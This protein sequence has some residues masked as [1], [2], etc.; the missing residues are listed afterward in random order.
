MTVD[1][2]T[3]LVA[4][5]TLVDELYQR[6]VGPKRPVRRGHRPELSDSEV[7]TL[8]VCAQW[9]G[10]SE[11][12]FLRFVDRYWR[13]YFPRLLGQSAFNRRARDLT[14]AMTALVPLVAGDL[15]AALAPYQVIDGVAMP[16]ARRA[17]GI[18]HRLFADE[19]GIGRGGADK[20]W[21]FGCKVLLSCAPSGAITGFVVGLADTEERWLAEAW[22]CWRDEPTAS[23]WDGDHH[24]L[25]PSH[26]RGGRHRGPT[27]PI[28]PRDGAGA[29]ACGPT[30]ADKGFRGAHWAAHWW[31]DYGLLIRTDDAYDG[32]DAPAAR[33]H[34]HSRRQIIETVNGHLE[35]VFH[36]HF[37]NARSFRGLRARLAAKLLAFNLGLRLNTLL[38]R[39]PLALPTLWVA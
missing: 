27:G 37:P 20:D 8:M 28:W 4:L 25:P 33:R 26:K 11:R 38:G 29:P 16:L 13:G 23:P 24:H 39:L 31:M 30:L 32:D 36:L 19:A 9:H 35:R 5:Y 6:H 12:G 15:G 10:R 34:H 14:G 22:A 21:Y 7:L 1:L 17:R 2:D 18:R 3:F